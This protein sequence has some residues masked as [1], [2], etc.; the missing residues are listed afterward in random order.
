MLP[1]LS[2][3]PARTDAPPLPRT[4]HPT[5]EL[6]AWVKERRVGLLASAAFHAL[7][8]VA[9]VFAFPTPSAFK[10]LPPESLE[11]EIVSGRQFAALMQP[12]LPA[13]RTATRPAVL[14][15]PPR[16]THA[17]K[18]LS[19]SA[20]DRVA[21]V[22]LETLRIDARFEQLCDVEA[23]EQI[24]QGERPFK[25][26]RAIAYATEDTQVDGDTL[27]ADG[28][29]FLSEG[30]WYHLAFKCRATPDR[31]TVLSFDFAIGSEFSERDPA[32]PTGTGD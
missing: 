23:M 1:T 4:R 17:R 19:G 27:T 15:A 9:A 25:P 22:S 16:L 13:P 2:S 20:L 21:S 32:L 10:A 24:T 12:P 3:P 8:G 26:E 6:A 28:A 5:A 30:H 7:L 18:I 29:A 31:R 14:P 11:V